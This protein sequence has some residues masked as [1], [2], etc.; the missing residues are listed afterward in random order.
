MLNLAR[1]EDEQILAHFT[2]CVKDLSSTFKQSVIPSPTMKT[3]Q[4]NRV[5]LSISQYKEYYKT[6][7]QLVMSLM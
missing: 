5:K 3:Q 2:S 7:S 6:V 4:W 1:V